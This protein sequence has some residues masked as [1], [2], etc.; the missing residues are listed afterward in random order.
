[1]GKSPGCS[2]DQGLNRGAWTV[3]EDQKLRDYI[4]THGEGKWRNIPKEAGK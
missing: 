4:K 1:M 2:K 3:L